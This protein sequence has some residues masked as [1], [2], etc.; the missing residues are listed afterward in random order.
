[1]DI[2]S[3]PTTRRYT[4][5][6]AR[7]TTV[8]TQRLSSDSCR[9]DGLPICHRTGSKCRYNASCTQYYVLHSVAPLIR[10]I[11]IIICNRWK[12]GN[13]S[14]TAAAAAAL[15]IDDVCY[16]R[17]IGKIVILRIMIFIIVSFHIIILTSNYI[18]TVSA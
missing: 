3:K 7:S 18:P 17:G 2:I 16:D 4:L 14:S 10:F 5:T 8:G 12:Y 1:M 9:L 15:V 11:K 6:A 13:M